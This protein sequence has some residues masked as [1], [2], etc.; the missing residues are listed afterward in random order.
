MV[1]ESPEISIAEPAVLGVSV[2]GD[3]IAT[4]V[5]D[6]TGE[7]VASNHVELA[8]ES[9]NA[10]LDALRELVDSAPFTIDHIVLTCARPDVRAHLEFSMN[11][12]GAP[13]WASAVS[14]V[15]LPH[16][17]AQVAHRDATGDVAAVVLD[18]SGA[19]A[20]G[21]SIALVNAEHSS[22]HASA[23]VAA[24]QSVP[25]TDPQGADG[26]VAHLN[27]LTRGAGATRVV[28]AGSGAQM[29]DSVRAIETATGSPVT[30]A[31][32][33]VFALA[34]GVTE[35]IAADTRAI[36]VAAAAV[37]P[38]A[39][40][41]VGTAAAAPTT[42]M[43]GVGVRWWIIGGA[44]GLAALLCV[45]ALVALFTGKDDSGTPAAVTST[46]TVP[47]PTSEVTVTRTGQPDT[48]T[49]VD[50]QTVTSTVTRPPVTSTATQTVTSTA[51]ATATATVTEQETVTSVVTTTVT[52]PQ[53]GPGNPGAGG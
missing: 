10:A 47:G 20:S 53:L 22:V 45:V 31:A 15:D 18:R 2:V 41:S 37:G 24:P 34:Q 13:E 30:V 29:P 12:P 40:A 51:T 19:L 25:L 48:Q 50:Q 32:A 4:V 8:D 17:L 43:G 52:A 42:A 44:A 28:A 27:S 11:A 1:S 9:P 14:F 6:A 33:P 26:L 36:P 23:A 49:V 5:R 16:A 3:E 38:A 7:I 46:V 39:A 21:A 35:V